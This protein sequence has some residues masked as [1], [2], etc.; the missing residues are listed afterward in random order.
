MNKI[1]VSK[2]QRHPFRPE[3]H[4]LPVSKNQD[5]RWINQTK[6]EVFNRLTQSNVKRDAKI[7]EALEEK[8]EKEIA[9]C[10]FKSA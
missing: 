1:T 5:Y 9:P 4:P 8:V 7:K 10:T 6:K 3:I 2:E